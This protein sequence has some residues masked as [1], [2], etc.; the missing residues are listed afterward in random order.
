MVTTVQAQAALTR[1]HQFF[2]WTRAMCSP[3]AFYRFSMRLK[4]R[5]QLAIR[6][7]QLC[8][9]VG[10]SFNVEA[11]GRSNN[12]P[13]GVLLLTSTRPSACPLSPPRSP[14]SGEASQLRGCVTRPLCTWL[15]GDGCRSGR[16]NFF[17]VTAGCCFST[18]HE[19]WLV[20]RVCSPRTWP[21]HS[22][23]PPRFVEPT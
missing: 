3:S 5:R 18:S 12:D 14:S 8:R 20:A 10:T 17:R 9:G 19:R 1:S 4:I 21:S 16:A 23:W 13:L 15:Q 2:T 6:V 11:L 22:R 7:P